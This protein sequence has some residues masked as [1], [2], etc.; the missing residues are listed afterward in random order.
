MLQMRALFPRKWEKEFEIL[1]WTNSIFR[2]AQRKMINWE[3][4]KKDNAR[5]VEKKNRQELKSECVWNWLAG[6]QN[7]LLGL[8][9][10]ASLFSLCR[11]S[12]LMCSMARTGKCSSMSLQTA[13]W[14][15]HCLWSLLKLPFAGAIIYYS[16]VLRRQSA[17]S[18]S[19]TVHVI[20]RNAS[21]ID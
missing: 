14:T 11:L 1:S 9:F 15:H 6:A 5:A 19:C 16:W 18:L 4:S 20:D 3:M 10:F 17:L 13:T 2:L 7:T 21:L 8:S 12:K